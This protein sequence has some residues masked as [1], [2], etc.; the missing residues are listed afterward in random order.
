MHKTAKVVQLQKYDVKGL[1][2]IWAEVMIGEVRVVAGSVYIPPGQF[3]QM[4]LLRD[5]LKKICCENPR[6]VL[7]MDAN[8][9]SILWD[10]GV[11]ADSSRAPPKDGRHVS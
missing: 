2:A 8:A 10:E 11:R 4:V 3:N 9:R 7:G 6:V 1:E 5:Q